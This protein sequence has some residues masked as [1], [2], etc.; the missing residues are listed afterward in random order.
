MAVCLRCHKDMLSVDGCDVTHFTL[1]K[2]RRPRVPYGREGRLGVHVLPPDQ[3]CRDCNAAVGKFHHP[4]C[5]LEEC[6]RCD[7]QVISCGCTGR[8]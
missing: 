4:G 2:K 8:R 7:G 1:G 5:D 3:R 6:P